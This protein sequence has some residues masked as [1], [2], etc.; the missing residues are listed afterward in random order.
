MGHQYLPSSTLPLLRAACLWPP[1][2]ALSDKGPQDP[3]WA[4][5]HRATKG[6]WPR[7]RL[8]HSRR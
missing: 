7:T 5:L 2:S 3:R 4:D 1:G 8:S 6:S